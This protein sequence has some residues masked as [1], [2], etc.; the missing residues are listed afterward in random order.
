MIDATPVVVQLLDDD[1][2]AAWD[3]FQFTGDRRITAAA[4]TA[5]AVGTVVEILG[6]FPAVAD[7]SDPLG[8]TAALFAYRP[9]R[10]IILGAPDDVI[11]WLDERT[12]ADE[13]TQGG[14]A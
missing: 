1:A 14:A 8:A 2:T 3:G 13:A 11:D 5:A 10:T 6:R 9:G 7:S 12:G 4:R